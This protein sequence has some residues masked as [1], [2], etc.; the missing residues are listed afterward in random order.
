M[1]SSSDCW[2]IE[3]NI[4]ASS[5][6][7]G[8]HHSPRLVPGKDD[9]RYENM[10]WHDDTGG[11]FLEDSGR[12]FTWAYCFTRIDVFHPFFSFMCTSKFL[13]PSTYSV[14]NQDETKEH[15]ILK[16]PALSSIHTNYLPVIFSKIPSVLGNK[17]YII[18][19]NELLLQL[20]LDPIH[21]MI[22]QVL[23]MQDHTIG[24]IEKVSQNLMY[25]L[26]QTR[27]QEMNA[28]L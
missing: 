23:P 17:P 4:G 20:L 22:S 27:F 19:N 13:L 5:K 6:I 3:A 16:C 24:E 21:L 25:A 8:S 14:M 11:C 9:L 18:N 7:P 1:P 10:M 2:N 12:D 26:H 15:F 28:N